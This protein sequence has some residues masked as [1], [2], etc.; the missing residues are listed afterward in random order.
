MTVEQRLVDALSRF[1][2]YEPSVDLFAR[3]NRSIEEDKAHRRRLI[4]AVASVTVA[5]T[6]IAGF[7]VGVAGRNQAGQIIVPKWS[8]VLVQ[9]AVMVPMLLVV[10]PLIRRFGQPFIDG[11]FHLNPETGRRFSRLLDI[12]YYLFFGGLIVAVAGI[13]ETGLDVMLML[14][15]LK[16]PYVDQVAGFMLILGVAHAVNLLAIP[17]VG[18]IYGAVTRRARRHAAGL[19]KSSESQRARTADR[20]ASW[21]TYAVAAWV[22]L[23]LVGVVMGLVGGVAP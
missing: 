9:I 1:D 18:L 4:V 5:L 21:I 2:E 22:I 13:E 6:A 7:L 15:E 19:S 3:T 17:V 8:V 11:A 12:A 20:V 16:D 10:G 14:S 23:Q